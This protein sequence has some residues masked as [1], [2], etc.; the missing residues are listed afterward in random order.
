MLKVI[1]NGA[2]AALFAITLLIVRG[3]WV[4][5]HWLYL[6]G[7]WVLAACLWLFAMFKA[8]KKLPTIQ[9]GPI[10]NSGQMVAPVFS[11]IR[12]STFH[13]SAS[14]APAPIVPPGPLPEPLSKAKLIFSG[15]ELKPLIF[16]MGR[17]SSYPAPLTSVIIWIENKV[18]EEGQSSEPAYVAATIKYAD[19]SD[20]IVGHISRAYWMHETDNG[21]TI[22][23]G[24]RDGIVLGTRCKQGLWAVFD[25]PEEPVIRMA[26]SRRRFKTY[27]DSLV[28]FERLL[29]IDLSIIDPETGGTI[30][31][32]SL[33]AEDKADG[34]LQVKL[35]S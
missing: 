14:T 24:G 16:G 27:R 33:E 26:S 10:Q 34:T 22:E 21:I 2:I 29:K 3:D 13:I 12:D 35:I 17:F 6:V 31:R 8:K 5:Q 4:R 18:A 11:G 9:T 28:S 20:S 23:V 15:Y 19:G 30:K 7:L 1:A 32:F 25:N